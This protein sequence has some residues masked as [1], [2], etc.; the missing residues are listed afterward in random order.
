MGKRKPARACRSW[1]LPFVVLSSIVSAR[2]AVAENAKVPSTSAASVQEEATKALARAKLIDGGERLKQ[3][4]YTAALTLFKEAYQ[5]VP[6]PKIFYNF[7]LA[8]T[9]LGRATEA[10][11]AFER[12]LDEA[13]DASPE[14]R[15]NAEKHRNDLLSQIGSVVVR[16][17]VD[18]AAISVD[19]RA[20][21]V[22]PRKNPVRLDPGPHSL[23][24]EKAPLPAFTQNINVAAGEKLIVDVHLNV[25]PTPAPQPVAVPVVVPPPPPVA[26]AP[27]PEP[28]SPP[29]SWKAKLAIGL[30]AAA[31]LGLG[32]GVYEQLAASS[33]YDQFNSYVAPNTLMKC[34]A[35][36]RVAGHGGG[37]CASLLSDGDS[38]SLAAKIGFAVGGALAVSSI[39]LF[40][41]SRGE[42]HETSAAFAG[43][44]P[45]GNGALCAVTF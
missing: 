43:C 17:D 10:V 24:V 41:L 27:P 32:F 7:G 3:G 37:N 22:T 20:K 23:V 29:M 4:D 40:I 28:E 42:H 26:P 30:G 1:L 11:E 19:G 6:S 5:L 34:D 31:V 8:Y 38:A 45:T 16:C 14:T 12:F 25:A 15:L 39:T 13:T 44:S 33:K 2:A 21:G 18:G 9:N 36:S 35:D